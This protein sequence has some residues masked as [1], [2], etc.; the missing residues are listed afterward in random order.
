VSAPAVSAPASAPDAGAAAGRRGLRP[1]LA[2]A[3]LAVLAV[4]VGVGLLVGPVH[5]PVRGA[6]LDA[7]D[8]LPFV[9][10]ASGLSAAQEAILWQL[11]L[12]RVVLGGLVGGTLALCGGAYQ[13]AFRNALA[14]PYLLGVAAGA[15]LGATV[16]IA[17]APG[18]GL[19]PVPALPLLAFAGGAAAVVLAYVVGRSA[20]FGRGPTTIVLA[21]VA[22]ASFLTAAQ[23]FLQQE[24]SETLREVYDWILGRL[25]T[26]GWGDVR[27]VLPYVVVASALILLHGRLLDVLSLGDEGA[28][29]LGVRPGRVRLVLVAAVTL[30]T[31]A[32]VAVS[33]LIGFVGIIVPHAVRLVGVTSYRALLPLA[34]VIG[35]AFL[36][37]ADVVARTAL[38]PAELPIGVVTAAIGAPAFALVLRSSHVPT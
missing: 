8:H 38:A 10:A 3:A 23:T 35:A 30:G 37:L 33:G 18:A 7:A 9:H 29:A 4:A 21:G 2:L 19:G 15:G 20:G 27:L 12:P 36:I 13:G 26:A 34:F 28:G 24:R 22:V 16:A 25:S 14:D 11:R 6:V 17:Y 32:V 5:V 1:V 31:A